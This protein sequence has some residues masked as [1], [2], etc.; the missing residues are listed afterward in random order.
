MKYGNIVTGVG[1]ILQ[2]QKFH[3]EAAVKY[4]ALFNSSFKG[5]PGRLD[6]TPL[7]EFY[8][9]MA[10]LHLCTRF[11]MDRALVRYHELVDIAALDAGDGLEP[12]DDETIA[13]G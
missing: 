5:G 9:E 2:A 11:K 3:T 12:G 7:E 4:A 1:L 6:Y 8:Q 10:Q 13:W